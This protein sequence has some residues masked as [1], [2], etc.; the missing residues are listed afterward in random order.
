MKKF[1]YSRLSLYE[2]CPR[3]FYYKYVLELEDKDTKPLALGKAVHKALECIINRT[4]F[5]EAIKQ[6]LI[7][8][9]FHPEVE[10]DEIRQLV[11]NAPFQKLKGETEVYFRIP[12]F[13]YPNSP[14]IEGYIDLIDGDRIYDYK[15]NRKM[16]SITDNYQIALYAWALS[17]IKGLS[18]VQGSLIFLRYKK[19]SKFVFNEAVMNEAIEWAKELVKEILFKLEMLDFQPNLVDKL[20]P[21]QPSRYCKHCPFVIDCYKKSNTNN[22]I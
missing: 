4:D 9:D 1:S 18:Q 13:D 16:Y 22:A 12:L 8:C 7:E 15:T 3:R 10:P 21:Y 14:K 6:G 17:R 2:Q 20:F 11:K 5:E 19:E